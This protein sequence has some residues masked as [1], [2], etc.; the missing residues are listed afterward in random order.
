MSVWRKAMPGIH[1]SGVCAHST[2]RPSDKWNDEELAVGAHKLAIVTLHKN[3]PASVGRD[4]GK[5]IAHAILRGPD[6]SLWRTALSVVERYPI[7]IVL[8]RGLVR[9]VCT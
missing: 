5:V 1:K 6:D 3:Y 8:N 2:R 9:I 7:E 4:L